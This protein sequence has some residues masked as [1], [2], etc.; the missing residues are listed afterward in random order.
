[1]NFAGGSPAAFPRAVALA[2]DGCAVCL[3]R[4]SYP[5]N[6][7]GEE[8]APFSRARMHFDS[9]VSRLQPSKPKIRLASVM[10]YQPSR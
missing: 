2:N 1:M 8:G 9:I 5:G 6:I 3:H 10:A 4:Q 7:D